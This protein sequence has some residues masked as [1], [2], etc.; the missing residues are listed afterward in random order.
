MVWNRIQAVYWDSQG[1]Q[2]QLLEIE[3]VCENLSD[4]ILHCSLC[5][6]PQEVHSQLTAHVMSGKEK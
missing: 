5:H 6:S 3:D 4:I 1:G 2:E